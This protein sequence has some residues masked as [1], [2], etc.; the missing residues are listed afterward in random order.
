MLLVEE[1]Q[2]QTRGNSSE[3]QMLYLN[4]DKWRGHDHG[5]RGQFGQGLN[6][7]RQ[8]HDG[9][10]YFP[11]RNGSTQGTFGRRGVFMPDQA[12]KTTPSN[13]DIVTKLATMKRTAERRRV[14]RRLQVENWPIMPL[15]LNTMPM[16]DC[17][18]WDIEWIVCWPPIR[19]TPLIRKTYGLSNVLH[20]TVWRLIK[21]SSETYKN[22][23]DPAMSRPEIIPFI[24]F[25]MSAMSHSGNKAN[26]LV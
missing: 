23:I 18:Q 12:V 11:Q 9:K 15:T 7:Q 14:S 4:S 8:S 3:C 26:K 20:Q 19:P 10:S 24:P 13:A 21:N 22:R 5:R 2:V 17:S 6:N 16:V 25:G 1:N